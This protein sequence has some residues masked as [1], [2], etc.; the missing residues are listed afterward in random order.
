MLSTLG[1]FWLGSLLRQG[2]D[3][4][5]DSYGQGVPVEVIQGRQGDS[6]RVCDQDYRTSEFSTREG[7][8][9]GY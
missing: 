8:E 9:L 2:C 7:R 4:E 5:C 1:C 6:H 3:D